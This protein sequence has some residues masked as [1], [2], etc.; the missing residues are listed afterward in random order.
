MI[1]SS[2]SRESQ[3]EMA[4]DVE[5]AV[6]G[7]MDLP[8]GKWAGALAECVDVLVSTY[9]RAGL[10]ED[11]AL[12]LAQRG[13]IAL[14]DYRGGRHLYLPRGVSLRTAVRDR[15]I[16]H[17]SGRVSS[18]TLAARFEL[19]VRRIEQIVHD[20]QRLHIARVQRDLFPQ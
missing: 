2:G 19:T 15:A 3:S 7:G 18:E 1:H 11:Q 9:K 17:L 12:D 5:Q 20:Q 14:A 8:P 16:F 13:V 10:D 6:A 4:L